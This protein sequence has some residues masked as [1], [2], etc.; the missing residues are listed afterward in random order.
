M[1]AREGLGSPRP[2]HPVVF[3]LLF[4][5]YGAAG[6]YL[7]VAI[8][9]LLSHAGMPVE[10]VAGLVALSYVPHTWKFLWAP[11]VAKLAASTAM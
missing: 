2:A 11:V 5:P 10:A 1:T 3:L 6:G 4:M 9:Y 7:T 8:A